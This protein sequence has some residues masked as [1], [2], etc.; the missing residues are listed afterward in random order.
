MNVGND[1]HERVSHNTAATW[2]KSSSAAFFIMSSDLCKK[3]TFHLNSKS[4]TKLEAYASD[5]IS[6]IV[7]FSDVLKVVLT[8]WN[9]YYQQQS[10]F[11][12]CTTRITSG[13]AGSHSSEITHRTLCT[14]IQQNYYK[15]QRADEEFL[16]TSASYPDRILSP[17]YIATVCKTCKGKVPAATLAVNPWS[18][19]HREPQR[20]S[21]PA[22]QL[23]CSQSSGMRCAQNIQQHS[24]PALTQAFPWK[25]ICV[26]DGASSPWSSQERQS[27]I[28]LV[29]QK[30]LLGCTDTPHLPCCLLHCH[31]FFTCLICHLQSCWSPQA[32]S[33][34]NLRSCYLR[35]PLC[36]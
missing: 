6:K 16:K 22:V 28:S 8:K 29:Q 32:L 33:S 25:A 21:P 26:L 19:S 7:T 13:H 4:L 24:A 23:P 9:I 27:W 20:N 34:T 15:F 36:N 17:G 35:C 3:I 10:G 2:N 1:A 14:H 31:V 30:V 18:L 5:I 12:K 11:T